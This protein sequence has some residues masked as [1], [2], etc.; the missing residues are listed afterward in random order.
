MSFAEKQ[1][2]NEQ[3][4]CTN[5]VRFCKNGN[6]YISFHGAASYKIMCSA[7]TEKIKDET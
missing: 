5:N 2:C 3:E 1:L 4:W 7:N 6:F